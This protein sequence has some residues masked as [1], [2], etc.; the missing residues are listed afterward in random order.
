MPTTMKSG[1]ALASRLK[2]NR[3]IVPEILANRL[4]FNKLVAA[5]DVKGPT[6]QEETDH[7]LEE[8]ALE[9]EANRSAV[10]PIFSLT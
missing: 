1:R 6:I 4:H 10:S 7:V 9:F 2:V 3:N 8:S 5:R